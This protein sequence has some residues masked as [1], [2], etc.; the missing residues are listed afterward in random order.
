MHETI[1][2]IYVIDPATG[3]PVYQCET[4]HQELAE[5]EVDRIND[6]MARAG[7]PCTAYYTP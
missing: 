7:V 4:I 1:C 6:N 3:A 5:N 2:T